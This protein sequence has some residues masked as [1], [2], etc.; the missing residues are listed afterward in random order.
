MAAESLLLQWGKENPASPPVAALLKLSLQPLWAAFL[1]L[2]RKKIEV[3]TRALQ[4]CTFESMLIQRLVGSSILTPD[5]FAQEEVDRVKDQAALQAKPM[6]QLLNFRG[7]G[8]RKAS[9]SRGRGN[10]RARSANFGTAPA[11]QYQQVMHQA[12]GR[13]F[14]GFRGGYLRQANCGPQQA[15]GGNYQDAYF[16]GQ[17]RA[18][19]TPRGRGRGRGNRGGRSPG[20]PRQGNQ[21]NKP[22]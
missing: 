7:T 5:L 11:P 3:R 22:F 14:G 6:F 20:T 17:R 4:G 2:A 12:A 13:G 19:S 18:P 1:S 9:A 8:K 15:P 21:A 10:K 16:S